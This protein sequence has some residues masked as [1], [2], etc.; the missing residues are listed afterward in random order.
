LDVVGQVIEPITHG[1]TR[2]ETDE[3]WG[4]P[5]EVCLAEI[6]LETIPAKELDEGVA[7]FRSPPRVPVLE[8]LL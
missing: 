8:C 1:L 7:F 2:R 4:S 6:G 5:N 3:K